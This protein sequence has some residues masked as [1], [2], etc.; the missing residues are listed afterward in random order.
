MDLRTPE[1]LEV[2]HAV[3]PQVE[4]ATRG[5]LIDCLYLAGNQMA[6]DIST[7]NYGVP[8]CVVVSLT[9]VQRIH[10]SHGEEPDGQL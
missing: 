2:F 7:K 6:K 3:I 8:L 10:E 1:G 9:K 5:S 4:S